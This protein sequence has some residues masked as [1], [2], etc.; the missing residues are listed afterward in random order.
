[1]IL[2]DLVMPKMDG[3]SATH[4]IHERWPHVQ[5][6]ALTSFHKRELVQE[7]L[8][9]GAIGYLLKNVSVEDLVEAIRAAYA[10]RSTLAPEAIQ[11][12]GDAT[13]HSNSPPNSNEHVGEIKH[14][15]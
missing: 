12:L 15:T 14:E 13:D 2:M 6:I 9:A 7:M 5:V 8:Q 11:A 1:V 10:G 4:I 3:V